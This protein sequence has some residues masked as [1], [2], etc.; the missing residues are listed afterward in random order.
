VA[1]SRDIGANGFLATFDFIRAR[2]TARTFGV[3]Q[4]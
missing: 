3:D 4:K 1:S 2:R